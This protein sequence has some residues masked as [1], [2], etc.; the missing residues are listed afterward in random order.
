MSRFDNALFNDIGT[1]QALAVMW[2]VVKSNTLSS[3]T[4]WAI[5]QDMD[6]V[7]GFGMS[8]FQ[9]ETYTPDAEIDALLQER[10]EARAA[11]NWARSD[12]IRNLLA[13]KGWAVKDMP[14]GTV[15]LTRA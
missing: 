2:E 12:E 4:K 14:D 6:T 10:K 13:E 15:Q 3:A 9:E 8:D 1:P 5:L 11:K 7:L